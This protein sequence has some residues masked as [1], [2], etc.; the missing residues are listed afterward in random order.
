MTRVSEFKPLDASRAIR[1]DE[2]LRGADKA[3]L[4]AAVFRT[5]NNTRKVRASLALLAKDA[6]FH[7]NTATTVF[8]ET[9]EAVLRYFEKIDRQARRLDLWFH[10]SAR[11]TAGM[12]RR[13]ADLDVGPTVAMSRDDAFEIARSPDSQSVGVG[14]TAGVSLTHS[15]CE[16]SASL[17]PTSATT[18]PTLTRP[19]SVDGDERVAST[20]LT[21]EPPPDPL[22]A[23][24]PKPS[25]DQHDAESNLPCGCFPGVS[26]PDCRGD[27]LV[28]SKHSPERQRQF[29]EQHVERDE[30]LG[31]DGTPLDR[32]KP[33]TGYR[34]RERA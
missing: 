12:S 26:C 31:I 2:T 32:E 30:G 9:N 23:A 21:A 7:A 19:S 33:F 5:D 27:V 28:R 16:P 18:T 14:L 29:Y 24:E 4:W 13:D 8:A 3:F 10:P 25:A 6:G 20:S 22:A 15:G 17:C 34:S 11:L 1:D